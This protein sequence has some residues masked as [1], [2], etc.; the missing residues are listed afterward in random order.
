MKT[1]KNMDEFTKYIMMEADVEAPSADFLNK[2]MDSVKL[3][4]KLSLS[5]VYK[6]LIS[7]SVWAIITAAII[8]LSI[9]I[10]TG[11]SQNPTMFS[12]IDLDI[13]NK[14]NS[15]NLLGRIHFS[16]TFTLSFVLFSI[17]VILQLVV[18]KNYFN[19]Q[20]IV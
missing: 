9:F 7:K 6:P 3:E 12:T 1:E 4:S 16:D 10:V 13:F 2:V 20:N 18:I 17:F 14:I 19:K 11:T 15:V 8:A 5:E